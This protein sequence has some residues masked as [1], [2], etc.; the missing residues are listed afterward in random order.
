MRCFRPFSPEQEHHQRRG[1][2]ET[3]TADLDQADDH[4]LAEAAPLGPGV[5]KHQSR[6][7]GCGS[8]GEQRR[9]E[10][11][12]YS[13][14]GGHGQ[15]QQNSAQSNYTGKHKGNDLRGMDGPGMDLLS[16]FVSQDHDACLLSEVSI[17]YKHSP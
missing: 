15:H 16:L 10:A 11:A 5:V 13:V 1:G 8:R 6:Y 3:E 9:P 12:A 17:K 14:A 4:R 7:A 2:H